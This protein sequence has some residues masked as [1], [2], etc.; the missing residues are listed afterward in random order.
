MVA[1]RY[2]EEVESMDTVGKSKQACVCVSQVCTRDEMAAVPA[3]CPANKYP[4]AV[5]DSK[6]VY[7]QPGNSSIYKAA[8]EVNAVNDGFRPRIEEALHFARCLQIKKVGFAACNAFTTE[9]QILRKL[10][11]QEGVEVVCVACQIGHVTAEDRGMPEL[12]GYINAICN[13]VAQAE[14]C[15][16]EKTEVN[17]IVGLCLGHDLLFTRYSQAPVSTLIVKD[18]MLANNPSAALYGHHVRRSLFK[19]SRKDNKGRSCA[20]ESDQLRR[21]QV[22]PAGQVLWP[23]ERMSPLATLK[24]VQ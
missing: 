8:C 20:S 12:S 3:Y 1:G 21:E 5:E 2:V 24:P 22:G 17:F 4:D 19:L 23:S 16:R 13:P 10:F 14:V 9:M 18:R 11:A 6:A 15:N 7:R